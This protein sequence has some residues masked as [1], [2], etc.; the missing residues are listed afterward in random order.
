LVRAAVVVVATPVMV[1]ERRVDVRGVGAGV[2]VGVVTAV[3][4]ADG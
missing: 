1:V 3:V 2:A 4:D